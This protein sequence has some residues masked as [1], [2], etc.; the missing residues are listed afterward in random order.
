MRDPVATLLEASVHSTSFM[1]SLRQIFCS[2]L[3]QPLPYTLLLISP[4]PNPKQTV[5]QKEKLLP[6]FLWSTRYVFQFFFLVTEIRRTFPPL[7]CQTP[8]RL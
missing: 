3:L 2:R 8:G 1:Q 5:V 6:I 4:L 7:F